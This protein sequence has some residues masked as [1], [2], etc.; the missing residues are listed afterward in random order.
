[1]SF[2]KTISLQN[3]YSFRP[4]RA[5]DI[6]NQ[7]QIF[8]YFILQRLDSF[9][10]NPFQSKNHRL[11]PSKPVFFLAILHQGVGQHISFY[12]NMPRYSQY[13]NYIICAHVVEY[14]EV[15]SVPPWANNTVQRFNSPPR[16]RRRYH[17]SNS[18]A[19]KLNEITRW[20]HPFQINL[21]I[22]GICLN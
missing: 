15:F 12:L 11:R 14:A 20:S 7:K 8:T 9:L 21:I 4:W 18:L 6:I 2:V 19:S 5:L 17:D 16:S 22:L 1:M 13:G 3:P 10:F